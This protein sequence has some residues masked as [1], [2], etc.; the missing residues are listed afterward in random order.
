MAATNH[1]LIVP[2]PSPVAQTNDIRAIKPPVEVP[3]GWAWLWWVLAIIIRSYSGVVWGGGD[4]TSAAV[5]I[6]HVRPTFAPA[7]AEQALAL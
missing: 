4:E 3:D 7:V 2:P 5:A 1:A 6:P